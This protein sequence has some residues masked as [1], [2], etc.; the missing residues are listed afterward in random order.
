MVKVLIVSMYEIKQ[1][2]TGHLWL[3]HRGGGPSGSDVITNSGLWSEDHDTMMVFREIRSTNKTHC[4]RPS[5]MQL[6]AI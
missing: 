6:I 2:P 5:V 1:L 4:V 3:T